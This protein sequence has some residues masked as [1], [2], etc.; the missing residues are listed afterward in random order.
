K[1][2]ITDEFRD[3]VKN[4]LPPVFVN[5]NSNVQDAIEQIGDFCELLA[6]ADGD[7]MVINKLL[8]FYIAL[9]AIMF[10]IFK[11]ILGYNIR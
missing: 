10:L 11:A 9:I 5:N 1:V 2:T 3:K 8:K 7:P 4:L 6:E